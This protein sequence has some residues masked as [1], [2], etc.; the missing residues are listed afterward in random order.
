M[1]HCT[2]LRLYSFRPFVAS[3]NL[4]G[5]TSVLPW[6][7]NSLLSFMS[8]HCCCCCYCCCCCCCCCCCLRHP[9]FRLSVLRTFTQVFDVFIS[10]FFF[11]CNF[12]SKI[13][14]M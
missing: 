8:I 3:L 12:Y 11:L 10:N 14:S 13:R 6:C 2:Q 5:I 7:V 1:R 4:L 9:E